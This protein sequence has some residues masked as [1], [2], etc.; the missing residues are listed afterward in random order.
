MNAQEATINLLNDIYQSCQQ[1][2]IV[3]GALSRKTQDSRVRND[4]AKLQHEYRQISCKIAMELAIYDNFND[5][6]SAY[7]GEVW[8]GGL[9][10]CMVNAGTPDIACVIRESND[11]GIDD[12]RNSLMNNKNASSNAKILAEELINLKQFQLED[13]IPYL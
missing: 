2:L 12:I 9:I 10:K 4:I 6:E 3:S 5:R 8:A 1:S 7:Q 13:I 11:T